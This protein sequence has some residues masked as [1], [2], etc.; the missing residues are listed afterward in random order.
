MATQFSFVCRASSQ[1]VAGSF[2]DSINPPLCR[3]VPFCLSVSVLVSVS[4]SVS[5]PVPVPFCGRGS[6]RVS[7]SRTKLPVR[8]GL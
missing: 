3:G 8:M 5:V 4:V 1:K 7:L 2:G 6:A